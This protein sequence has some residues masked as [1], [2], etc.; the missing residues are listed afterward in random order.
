[1]D[2][3]R[4]DSLASLMIFPFPHDF[5]QKLVHPCVFLLEALSR[6]PTNRRGDDEDTGY[7]L[8]LHRTAGTLLTYLGR[9]TNVFVAY[10]AL[11]VVDWSWPL[12]HPAPR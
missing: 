7:P 8:V 11:I 4:L 12:Q 6:L 1:M 2:I 10:K 9:H 3:D 5:L